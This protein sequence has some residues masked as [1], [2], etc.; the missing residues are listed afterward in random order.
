MAP[1]PHK[2]PLALP[3]G[4]LG[5]R[6]HQSSHGDIDPGSRKWAPVGP[7]SFLHST[8]SVHS[9]VKKFEA[10]C[11]QYAPLLGPDA[12][13]HCGRILRPIHNPWALAGSSRGL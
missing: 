3:Q 11:A 6:W 8:D 9:G 5:K 7:T 13:A 10:R 2:N 1:L 12:T 4:D